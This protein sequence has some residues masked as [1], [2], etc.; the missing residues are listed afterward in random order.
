MTDAVTPGT[1][2]GVTAFLFLR[3]GATNGKAS[4]RARPPTHAGRDATLSLASLVA[5]EQHV[6]RHLRVRR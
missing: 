5:L 2:P 6:R 3:D 1:Q 4:I